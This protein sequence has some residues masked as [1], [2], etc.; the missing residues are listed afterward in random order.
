MAQ[1]PK[2]P[3]KVGVPN[4]T[5]VKTVAQ[6]MKGIRDAVEHKGLLKREV[7]DRFSAYR[8]VDVEIAYRLRHLKRLVREC[9]KK[10]KHQR[11]VWE[12]F[13][14]DNDPACD[15]SQV[16]QVDRIISLADMN[17]AGTLDMTARSLNAALKNPLALP[18]PAT[19]ATAAAQHR[20]DAKIISE[21]VPPSPGAVWVET[22]VPPD[23]GYWKPAPDP[24]AADPD[25]AD[26]P[27]NDDQGEDEDETAIADKPTNKFDV[28]RDGVGSPP[29]REPETKHDEAPVREKGAYIAWLYDDKGN[30]HRREDQFFRS[31]HTWP[32]MKEWIERRARKLPP[33]WHYEIYQTLP[34]EDGGSEE[35]VQICPAVGT[36]TSNPSDFQK[37]GKLPTIAEPEAYLRQNFP[38]WAG[39]LREFYKSQPDDLILGVLRLVVAERLPDYEITLKPKPKKGK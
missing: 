39:G 14:A 17:D 38:Q 35:L 34:A 22:D 33:G 13:V 8:Q 19:P 18:A 23:F 10:D 4:L 21:R 9:G 26:E 32:E 27:D 6:A 36:N 1:K 24:D 16:D 25:V 5:R 20:P 7:L 2:L 12:K 30:G 3:A 28:D 11:V 29:E 31:Q 37:P 15:G